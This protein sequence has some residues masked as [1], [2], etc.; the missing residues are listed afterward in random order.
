[1]CV[2]AGP[3]GPPC[4]QW[5]LPNQ[6]RCKY[7]ASFGPITTPHTATRRSGRARRRHPVRI[8]VSLWLAVW[9]S[10]GPRISS[11]DTNQPWRCLVH[12]RHHFQRDLWWIPFPHS[13]FDPTLS[14]RFHIPIEANPPIITHIPH[15]LYV[16]LCVLDGLTDQQLHY[17]LTFYYNAWFVLCQISY[18]IK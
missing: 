6:R 17:R 13:L 11:T 8:A 12:Y 15:T 3:P 1:M 9:R 14:R 16:C 18:Y 10:L 4:Q 2:C 7:P 5:P